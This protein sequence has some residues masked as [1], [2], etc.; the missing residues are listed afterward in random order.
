MIE[1]PRGWR[2][3]SWVLG[4]FGRVLGC[5]THEAFTVPQLT[6][7]VSNELQMS[8]NL[9]GGL[10]IA[11]QGLLANLGPIR[12]CLT[13]HTKRGKRGTPEDIGVPECKTDNGENARMPE[14]NTYAN[15]MHMMT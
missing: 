4:H 2:G 9:T 15:A 1:L 5:N 6:V 8:R 7:G 11:Y 10:P 13:P 14:T 3:F 12:E